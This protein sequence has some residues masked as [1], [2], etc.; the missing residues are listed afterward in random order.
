MSKT[1]RTKVYNFDELNGTAKKRALEHFRNFEV[2]HEWW[3]LT[4][5]DFKSIAA[6]IGIDVDSQNTYFRG[7]NSQSDGVAISAEIDLKKLVEGIAGKVWEKEWGEPLTEGL[8]LSSCPV[9]KRVLS[10]VYSHA[11]DVQA[12]LIPKT[13]ISYS[14]ALGYEANIYN[15]HANIE[16]ELDKLENW[17]QGVASDLSDYLFNRLRDE[18]DYLTSD[19]C[20]GEAI[21]ANEYHFTIDGRYFPC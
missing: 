14:T 8:G 4:Y 1:I 9:D 21:K 19:E 7:F 3:E 6:T 2:N 17:L 18:Y 5:Y 11:I 12:N 16:R 20:V 15:S 10:L 13:Q